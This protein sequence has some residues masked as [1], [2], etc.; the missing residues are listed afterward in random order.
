MYLKYEN[1]NVDRNRR[2]FNRCEALAVLKQWQ[3]H[4][5]DAI[6][7]GLTDSTSSGV[8]VVL[9]DCGCVTHVCLLLMLTR[10][11]L[12]VIVLENTN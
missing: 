11:Y 6:N 12:C 2:W 4:Y 5:L 7:I 8:I 9:H 3:R 1:C 10:I